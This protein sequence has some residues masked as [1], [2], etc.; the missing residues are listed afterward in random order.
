MQ[1]LTTLRE[2]D[3]KIA[4]CNRAE[5]I[6]D[7]AMRAVFG[8]FCMAPP[9]DLPADPFTE[10]YRQAQLALYRGIAERPYETS[11]EVTSFNIE[12]ALRRPFPFSTR[13][14]VTTGE[15]FMAIG[16]LLRA[17]ALPPGARVIE[18]GPGWGHTTLML[19][20][21]GHRVTA[22][23]IEPRF[24][25]LIRRRAAQ[26]GLEIEVV[27][28]DFTWVER[29]PH[30]FDAALFF[31]CF[32]HCAD[33]LRLLRAL[34]AALAPEARIFFAGEP[35][36]PDFPMPWGLRLDGNSLWAIRKNGWLELG[37]REDYFRQALQQAGWFGFKL[38][39]RDPGWMTLWEARPPGQPVFRATGA[40][41]RINTQIGRRVGDTIEI[42]GSEVGTGLYGPYVTLPPGHYT[43]RIHFAREP[44]LYGQARMDVAA[45][46]GSQIL[47]HC[48]IDARALDAAGGPVVLPF[49][50]DQEMPQVEVRLFCEGKFRAVIEAVEITPEIFL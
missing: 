13:S 27:N 24:C 23:D 28:D 17:M 32:H 9:R 29:A 48:S 39:C 1:I 22:V 5:A 34:R 43:A 3:D 42:A 38:P 40:D 10:D 21:L 18:F 45:G 44:Y 31:E 16:A 12:A 37:F 25:E 26:E 47:A 6:S 15:Y 11:N 19:A 35:I 2:L 41:P 14:G 8:T 33:H 7:D 49:G 50:S 20:K 46:I 30:R 4:E 36:T